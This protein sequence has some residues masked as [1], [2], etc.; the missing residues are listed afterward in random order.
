MPEATPT[1][2][3]RGPAHLGRGRPTIG[4]RQYADRL[5]DQGSRS[6]SRRCRSTWWP[7]GWARSQRLARAAAITAATTGLLTEAAEDDEPFGFCLATG[8]PASSSAWT[9]STSASS[10]ASA[11]CTSSP[12][13]TSSPAGPSSPLCSGPVNGTHTVRFVD[14]VLRHYRKHGVRVRAVLSDN[15]PEYVAGAFVGPTGRQGAAARSHPGPLAQPQ[16]RRASAS[17][18]PSSKSAGARPSTGATSP[19]SASSRPKPTP[20]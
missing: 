18:A 2:V 20:G 14:Q 19:R 8:G 10:R 7:T 5:G 16:R 13:S 11:R 17:T 6:P 3:D 4:C 9:A 1:H 12:P 15:G